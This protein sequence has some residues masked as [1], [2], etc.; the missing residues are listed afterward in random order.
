MSEGPTTKRCQR[1]QHAQLYVIID[2]QPPMDSWSRRV[3]S[4]VRAGV[5]VVQLRD[6]R[7]ADRHLLERARC[8][9]ELTRAS[10]TM[11]VM[12][13]R[14]DLALLADADGVH[15]GQDELAVGDVR[16]ILGPER[17]V[18]VSTHSVAQARQAVQDGA[19]YIGVG[20]TFPSTTKHFATFTGPDLLR[21][22][23]SEVDLPAFAIGGINL[24]NLDAVLTT[25]CRRVVVGGAVRASEDPIATV[26]RIRSLLAQDPPRKHETEE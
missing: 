13:D 19:D 25:G 12:N 3:Q 16:R 21:Q 9:R 17:L 22:V 18:G 6:K 2:A 8:L 15:V 10:S 14:A 11:F 24:D 5:D 7:L 26:E 1:L 23:T 4:L 20:P